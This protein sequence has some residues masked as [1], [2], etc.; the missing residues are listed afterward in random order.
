MMLALGAQQILEGYGPE[1]S[2]GVY[3]SYVDI[4]NVV[5]IC[6]GHTGKTVKLGQTATKEL[7]DAIAAADLTKDFAV[8]DKYIDRPEEL[9]PWVRAAAALFIDNVGAEGFHGST[10]LKLLN[11]RRITDACNSMLLWNK[12]RVGGGSL[13]VVLGLINRREAERRLCLGELM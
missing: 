3:R 9:E 11:Q 8:E 6:R 13:Q 1:V 7:C 12:A 4:A 2:P 10:F 5:T